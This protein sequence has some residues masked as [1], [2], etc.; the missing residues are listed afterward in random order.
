MASRERGS[1]SS[2]ADAAFR[3][4]PKAFAENLKRRRQAAQGLEQ[5]LLTNVPLLY[6]SP[7]QME[8]HG[9][10]GIV[11]AQ[12]HREDMLRRIGGSPLQ[13]AGRRSDVVLPFE[14]ATAALAILLWLFFLLAD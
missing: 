8:A 14:R 5:E 6:G 13:A 10:P 11:L 9:D 1:G 7:G 12:L 2:A 4:D 3:D